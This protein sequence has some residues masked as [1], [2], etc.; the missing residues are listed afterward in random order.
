MEKHGW[1]LEKENFFHTKI[2]SKAG[3]GVLY[4]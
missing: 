3:H 1:S 2:K 4:L